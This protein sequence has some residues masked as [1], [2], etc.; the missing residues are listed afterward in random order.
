MPG[1]PTDAVDHIPRIPLP[2][3]Q[4]DPLLDRRGEIRR[5]TEELDAVVARALL[6]D[7]VPVGC[8][9]GRADLDVLE[10]NVV[11]RAL[12]Q[13][14]EI[15]TLVIK[16]RRGHTVARWQLGRVATS[17]NQA[18]TVRIKLARGTY[19]CFFKARDLAGNTQAKAGSKRL[20]VR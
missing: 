7:L 17:K 10:Q 18:F 13:D 6:A 14:L 4:C 12:G 5:V 9:P 11:R 3:A 15:A 16:N 19:T 20:I 2:H 1:A 8:R